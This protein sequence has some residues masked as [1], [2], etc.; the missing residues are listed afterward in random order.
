[1][2]INPKLVINGLI[3]PDLSSMGT[4]PFDAFPFRTKLPAPCQA[5]R[6]FITPRPC[7]TARHFI[8][9]RFI[10]PHVT[11]EQSHVNHRPRH[12]ALGVAVNDNVAIGPAQL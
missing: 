7:Q 5:T 10:T 6:S 11:L 4:V 9:G 2:M 8:T 12:Q 1:M 3:P